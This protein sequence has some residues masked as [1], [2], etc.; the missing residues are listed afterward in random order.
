MKIGKDTI[1]KVESR[2]LL[3]GLIIAWETGCRQLELEC[4]NALLVEKLLVGGAANSRIPELRLIHQ[5][6]SRNWEVEEKINRNQEKM[7]HGGK[8]A[9][10]FFQNLPEKMHWKGLFTMFSCHGKVIDAFIPSKCG[11]DGRRF[12]FVRFA[13]LQDATRELNR[14]NR[15]TEKSEKRH[16]S[17][18]NM[19]RTEVHKECD[20]I[21][22]DRGKYGCMDTNCEMVIERVIDENMWNILQSCIVA[23]VNMLLICENEEK[24]KKVLKEQ[25]KILEQ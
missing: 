4:D 19:E 5:L 22:G 12:G 17:M 11:S 1:F 9:S 16:G 15:C 3:E 14:L 6:L 13:Y 25:S 10:P 18:G 23:E 2:A 21:D 8:D 7:R 24:A 20:R